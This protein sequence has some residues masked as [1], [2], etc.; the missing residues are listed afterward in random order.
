MLLNPNAMLETENLPKTHEDHRKV[1]RPGPDHLGQKT[2][3][4]QENEQVTRMK[5]YTLY[6]HILNISRC[7]PFRAGFLGR[8]LIGIC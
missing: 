3:P 1:K 4:G 5:Y 8:W 6:S 7:L 2:E